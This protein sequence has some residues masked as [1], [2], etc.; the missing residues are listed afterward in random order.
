MSAKFS[1]KVWELDLKPTEK[2]VLLALSDHADHEG[3]NVRPGND[4]LVAKT[5]LTQQTI[6]AA[7]AKFVEQGILEPVTDCT[8]RGHKREFNIVLDDAP[9]RQYFIEREQR[10][11]QAKR[12]FMLKERYNASVPFDSGKVQ[13]DSGKVQNDSGKVQNDS[14]AYKEYNRQEPSKNRE[15]DALAFSPSQTSESGTTPFDTVT[16]PTTTEREGE[17]LFHLIHDGCNLPP[18]LD[19]KTEK[20]ILECVTNL[21]LGNHPLPIVQAMIEWWRREKTIALTPERLANDIGEWRRLHYRP[22]AT[23][24]EMPAR[25]NIAG[26]SLGEQK[27]A[28]ANW[29][30]Q[31][32]QIKQQAGVTA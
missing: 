7:L 15:R 29:F 5:G 17:L 13:N 8:G 23:V 12:T 3:E 9:R 22:Q 16:L 27:T 25:P 32:E 20:R 26:M 6:T 21:Q 11:V 24:L 19:R 18:K 30:Q 14:C 28:I 10:K 1:G 2:L 31:C 4:L